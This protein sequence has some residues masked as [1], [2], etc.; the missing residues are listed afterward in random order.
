M[1]VTLNGRTFDRAHLRSVRTFHCLCV[2]AADA[3]L[4]NF[5]SSSS[6]EREELQMKSD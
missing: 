4:G 5:P 2:S 6:K 3:L 1:N